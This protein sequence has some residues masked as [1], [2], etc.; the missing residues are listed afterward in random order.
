MTERFQSRIDRT[1]NFLFHHGRWSRG[2]HGA[3]SCSSSRNV[4]D[5]RRISKCSDNSCEECVLKLCAI[6]ILSFFSG[7]NLKVCRRFSNSGLI[8]SESADSAQQ[9][10]GSGVVGELDYGQ[11]AMSR[12]GCNMEKEPHYGR[13]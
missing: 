12:L 11:D 13:N 1:H 4:G 5:G 8:L 7:F 10:L 9:R 2:W 3:V 6:H